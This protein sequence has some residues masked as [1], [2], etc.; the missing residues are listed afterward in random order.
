[1]KFFLSMAFGNS[2]EFAGSTI[3]VKAQGLGQG[4]CTSLAGWCVISI[5]ILWAHGAKGH[6]AH[7]IAPMSHVCSSLSAI[8]YIN[9]TD[10]LHL[11]MDG[12]KTIFK[13]H[14]TL[15][16]AIK[17][18]GKLLIATGGTLKPEKCIFHLI[19]FQWTQQGGWQ[20]IGHHEDE[21]A[22]VFVL[23]PNGLTAPIQHR[24]VDDAQKTLGIVTC[25]SGNSMSS[26]TLM[27]EK[28]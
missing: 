24:V 15:Q 14:A 12:N 18:W 27:E 17:N 1:M 10:L 19:D 8:L 11:N 25:T 9:D 6:G 23:L 20:Y 7:F 22:A 3:E 26:L 4:N 28:T 21:T 16:R 5:M 13:T 2:K